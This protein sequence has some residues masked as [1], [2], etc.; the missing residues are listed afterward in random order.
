MR[1]NNHSTQNQ[2]ES[3]RNSSSNIVIPRQQSNAQSNA[4]NRLK[5]S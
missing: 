4:Q 2:L 5:C 3:V 1:I